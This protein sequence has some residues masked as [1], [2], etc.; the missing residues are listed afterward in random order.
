MIYTVIWQPSAEAALA[1]LWNDA[2][3]RAAVTS[4]A[5]TIDALLRQNPSSRGESR[6]GNFRV[7]FVAPWWFTLKS[8]SRTEWSRF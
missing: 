7:L 3:D 6:S 2:L 5:D 1:T 8:Q 4:A